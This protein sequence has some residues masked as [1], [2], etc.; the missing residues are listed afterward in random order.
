MKQRLGVAM[1]IANF[2]K[3]LILDEPTNGLDPGMEEMCE[4]IKSLPNEYGITVMISSHILD[5]MEKMVTNIGIINKGQL[6]EG[7]LGEL[8]KNNHPTI[9]FKT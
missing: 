6:F 3:L 7:T 9:Q 1:A 8:K 4:L 5:E 2:P